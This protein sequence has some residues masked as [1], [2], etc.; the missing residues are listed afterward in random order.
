MREESQTYTDNL[1][2]ITIGV[3]YMTSNQ[4]PL[5]L[6]GDDPVLRKLHH[7]HKLLK[8]ASCLALVLEQHGKT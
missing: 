8:L 4:R 5:L 2:Y 6:R 7:M 1:E 3:S